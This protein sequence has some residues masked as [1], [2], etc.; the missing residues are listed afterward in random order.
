LPFK[1]NLH[2]YTEALAAIAEINAAAAHASKASNYPDAELVE[3][4]TLSPRLPR[5]FRRSSLMLRAMIST[6]RADV[7][8]EET[9]QW[10][11]ER[12]GA[13]GP[14]SCPVT[15]FAGMDGEE[16]ESHELASWRDVVGICSLNQVDP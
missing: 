11:P 13:V 6:M 5:H 14:I 2:R 7:T 9:Y 15:V 8:A 4:L 1:F 16:T 12:A 10:Q 3:L